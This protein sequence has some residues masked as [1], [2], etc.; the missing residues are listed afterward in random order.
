MKY[1]EI[2]RWREDVYNSVTYAAPH[3][4]PGKW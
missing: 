1:D 3:P 4:K 2:L